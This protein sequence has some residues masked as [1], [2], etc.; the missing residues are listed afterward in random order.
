[1]YLYF[2]QKDRKFNLSRK[3]INKPN[4]ILHAPL[5]KSMEA[6]HHAL[7]KVSEICRHI[8][9]LHYQQKISLLNCNLEHFF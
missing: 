2:S 5:A 4:T 6:L 1:M 7:L 8:S 9:P 3:D